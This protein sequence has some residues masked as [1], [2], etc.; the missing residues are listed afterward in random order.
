MSILQAGE[1]ARST[2]HDTDNVGFFT[3][4]FELTNNEDRDCAE[5]TPVLFN[6][7]DMSKNRSG[8]ILTLKA[9]GQG[10]K[11]TRGGESAANGL[12]LKGEGIVNYKPARC[13]II[14]PK[15]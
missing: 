2:L 9:Y 6:A 15:H 12:L 5:V 8:L 4:A 3:Q 11:L 14:H 1:I 10:Q 7:S 13:W